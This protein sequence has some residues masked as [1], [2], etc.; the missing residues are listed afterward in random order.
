MLLLIVGL[1]IPQSLRAADVCDIAIIA[2]KSDQSAILHPERIISNRNGG[3]AS[4]IQDFQ[5][6]GECHLLYSASR[7]FLRETNLIQVHSVERVKMMISGELG[8]LPELPRIEFDLSVRAIR[9]S[10][11]RLKISSNGKVRWCP[12]LMNPQF[13]QAQTAVSKLNGSRK[14]IRTAEE[15]SGFSGNTLLRLALT[16]TAGSGVYELPIVREA[17]FDSSRICK[18]NEL[19]LNFT[20]AESGT[21][22]PQVLILLLSVRDGQ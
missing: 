14:L 16:N 19:M 7:P 6:A 22:A 13:I 4:A 12:E 8:D 2:F 5:K 9:Q 3:V 21:T 20:I 15:Q 17:Q 18:P 1:V 11:T 10:A